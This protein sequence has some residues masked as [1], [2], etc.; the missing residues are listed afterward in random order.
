VGKEIMVKEATRS[1][2]MME[3]KKVSHIV[4]NVGGSKI[5]NFLKPCDFNLCLERQGIS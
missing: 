5:C 1:E 4:R 3:E 2:E